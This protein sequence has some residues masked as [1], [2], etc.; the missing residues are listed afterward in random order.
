GRTVEIELGMQK[1]D[2]RDWLALARGLLR[3][4]V[5][6]QIKVAG[7][8]I[9]NES[10]RVFALAGP[11]GS[12]K[13][14]TITKLASM[15]ALQQGLDVV[16]VTLDTYRI[17]SVDHARRYAELIGVPLV[18]ADRPE[19]LAPAMRSHADADVVLVDTPGRAFEN[20]DVRFA[21]VDMVHAMGEPVETHLIMDATDAPAQQAAV[22]DRYRALKPSSVVVT[23]LDV[24]L[25]P[26]TLVNVRRI[27]EMPIS[28]LA[29]GPRIPED[30]EVADVGRVVQLLLGTEN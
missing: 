24:S 6:R 18:V 4:V 28:Y 27:A 29:A 3:E 11:S 17:G 22:V 23:K 7:P 16:M 13:T 12:G 1:L 2:R 15:L 9:P 30:I 20:D 26:G 8:I 5:A 19:M 10:R 25:Q 21:L 14:T